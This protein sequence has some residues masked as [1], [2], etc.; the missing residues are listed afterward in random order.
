MFLA[1]N[2]LSLPF[3]VDKM[4]KNS[5]KF[6]DQQEVDKLNT[7]KEEQHQHSSHLEDTRARREE[8]CAG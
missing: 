8:A 4:L 2:R 1:T 5:Q 3:E 6:R 7:W